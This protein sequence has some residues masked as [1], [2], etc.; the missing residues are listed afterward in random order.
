MSLETTISE[1]KHVPKATQSAVLLDYMEFGR[2]EYDNWSITCPSGNNVDEAI[3]SPGLEQEF[4]LNKSPNSPSIYMERMSSITGLKGTFNFIDSQKV[5][6]FLFENFFL[7]DIIE[8]GYPIIKEIFGVLPLCL[9]LH[10]D[11]EEDFRE[12]FLIIKSSNS[13]QDDLELLNKLDESWFLDV[14]DK[15]DNKFN[16]TVESI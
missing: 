5:S 16:I 13:P 3:L 11:P 14:L 9:E 8:E 12:L 4:A 15:T 2:Y 1:K 7:V 6:S 10:E